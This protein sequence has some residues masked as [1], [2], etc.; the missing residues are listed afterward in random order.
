MRW[1]SSFKFIEKESELS[2]IF[3]MNMKQAWFCIINYFVY[4]CLEFIV[5]CMYIH[6]HMEDTDDGNTEYLSVGWWSAQ[7]TLF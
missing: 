7:N 2:I 3:E 4:V 5:V 6:T 1:F